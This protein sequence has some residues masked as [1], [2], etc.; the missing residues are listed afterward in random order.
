MASLVSLGHFGTPFWIF[1]KQS[2]F[3]AHFPVSLAGRSLR[4]L[5]T[6]A[7]PPALL[8]SKRVSVRNPCRDLGLG[9]L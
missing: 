1:P 9:S 3:L 5:F 6:E 8:E 7:F 4:Q 2:L